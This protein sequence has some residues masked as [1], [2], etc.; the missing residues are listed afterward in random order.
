MFFT[1]P[2]CNL[3]AL[4]L[5]LKDPAAAFVLLLMKEFKVDL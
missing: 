2:N 3:N 1:P 5:A 4:I